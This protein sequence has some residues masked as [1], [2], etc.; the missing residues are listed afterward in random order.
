MLFKGKSGTAGRKTGQIVQRGGGS[1]MAGSREAESAAMRQGRHELWCGVEE[2]VMV[3]WDLSLLT[4][5]VP[6][7]SGV[8]RLCLIKQLNMA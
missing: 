6:P 2:S 7:Q 8:C 5:L 3:G 1:A 4:S